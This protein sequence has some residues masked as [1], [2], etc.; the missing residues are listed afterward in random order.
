MI[1][2]LAISGSLRSK[3]SNTQL[4]DRVA[5]IAGDN[6]SI[7][8]FSDLDRLPH[9]NPD[10][11]LSVDI[12]VKDLMQRMRVADGFFVSTP[13]YAHGIPGTLKNALDWLVGSDAFI[14]K[15]FVLLRAGDRSIHS[16][17]SLIEILTTGIGII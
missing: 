15:P 6:L 12:F 2:L 8:I 1:K 10:D 7:D 9:F 14:E 13:E 5:Q 17:Q 16:P 11:E 4:V 3:S